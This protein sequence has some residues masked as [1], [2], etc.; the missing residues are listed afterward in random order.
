MFQTNFY[1]FKIKYIFF[2]P[3]ILDLDDFC[4]QCGEYKEEK[5]QR[6]AGRHKQKPP[7]PTC[8]VLLSHN[9]SHSIG[10]FIKSN[11][12]FFVFFFFLFCFVIFFSITGN[13]L[14]YLKI[15]FIKITSFSTHQFYFLLLFFIFIF[16]IFIYFCYLLFFNPY[17]NLKIITTAG[18]CRKRKKITN[19]I[20]INIF[21]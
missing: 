11:C 3:D 21:F 6:K 7:S 16:I 12:T 8:L 1:N 14:Y 18:F 20:N 5:D 10:S 9:T 2:Y 19:K 17:R 4:C 15:K 13:K